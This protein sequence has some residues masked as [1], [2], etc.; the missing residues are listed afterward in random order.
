V[1]QALDSE[2]SSLDDFADIGRR[3][4]ERGLPAWVRDA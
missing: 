2:L 4:V 3:I 1:S